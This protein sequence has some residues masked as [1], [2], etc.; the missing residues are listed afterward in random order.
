MARALRISRDQLRS[1]CNGDALAIRQFEQ[2]F[3][4]V[5]GLAAASGGAVVADGDY[6][7]IVVSDNGLTWDIKP[8]GVTP[9]AYTN[10]SVTVA[11]DGRVT[12]AA[13]GVAGGPP[14]GPAGGDLTGT[15]PNPDIA[16]GAVGTPELADNAVTAAKLRDSIG[17]SV[18]GRSANSTGD[19][20]DIVAG[21]SGWVLRRSGTALGFG[22]VA[23]AGL[24]DGAVTTAKI[25]NNAVIAGKI[26][27]DAVINTKLAN[28]AAGTFKA[29]LTGTGDPEDLTGTQ[30]AT[31]LDV[32]TS[33]LKGLAPASGGGTTNFLRADGTWAVPPDTDT[34]ITQ[35]TGDVTAGPGNGSQAA[36]IANNAVTTAKILNANVTADKLADSAVTT[37]K[38]NNN[39][40]TNAKLA[41]MGGGTIKGCIS[42]GDPVDLTGA[43]ATALLDVFTTALK[44]LA[45][46]SGGGTLNLLRADGTWTS[47][48]KGSSVAT[49]T[50]IVVSGTITLDEVLEVGRYRVDFAV[51]YEIVGGGPSDGLQVNN[52]NSGGLTFSATNYMIW[53][54]EGGTTGSFAGPASSASF[55]FTGAADGMSRIDGVIDVTAAGTLAFDLAVLGSPTEVTIKAGSFLTATR[56]G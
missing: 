38:V 47:P 2:L 45:P 51:F 11:A 14:T 55:I 23:T 48:A 33:A 24:A 8:S 20:V 37:V 21:L 36:T 41:D 39:A 32:F 53:A 15:Y 44:G 18:I 3:S 4:T 22:E 19:S 50:D 31:L 30:A 27:D 35:L 46:A 43:Q 42:G 5:D 17:L 29:R 40:I 34:G 49:D 56:I 16:A 13:S 25:N 1:I 9:G 52:A 28:M 26:A 54:I 12:A 7:D 6:V 10:A